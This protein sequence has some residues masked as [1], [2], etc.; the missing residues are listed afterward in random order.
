MFGA[1]YIIRELGKKNVKFIVNMLMHEIETFSSLSFPGAGPDD[2]LL[3][4]AT[5][6]EC[7]MKMLLSFG[8]CLSQEVNPEDVGELLHCVHVTN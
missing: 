6:V 2:G 7:F 5:A 3:R 1:R 8:R 4:Y